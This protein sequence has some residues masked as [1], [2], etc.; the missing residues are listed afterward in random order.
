MATFRMG[1]APS[2]RIELIYATELS[3]PANTLEASPVST[4]LAICQGTVDHVWVRWRWGVGNLGG[5]QILHAAF[6][7][8][9]YTQGAWFPSFYESLDW[10]DD[11]AIDQPPYELEVKGYNLDDTYPHTVWVGVNILRGGFAGV[12][13]SIQEWL[14]GGP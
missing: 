3:I 5:V 14:R 2:S 4:A 7:R 6:V 13:R 8:W 11:L 9:P 10:Q 12:T 1:L